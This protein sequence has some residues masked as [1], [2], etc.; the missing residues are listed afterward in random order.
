M[1]WTDGSSDR[2]EMGG[3]WVGGYGVFFL[4]GP[5]CNV[6]VSESQTTGRVELLAV[7]KAL[8]EVTM[9][10]KTCIM[11]DSEYVVNGCNGWAQKWCRND[12]CTAT[13]PVA[14]SD[15]WKRVL[16]LLESYG[17]HVTVYHV[18][19]HAGLPDNAQ[20]D[21]LASQGRLQSPL[22]TANKLLLALLRDGAREEPEQDLHIV[23][24]RESTPLPQPNDFVPWTPESVLSRA[25]SSVVIC[26]PEQTRPSDRM[27]INLD[28]PSPQHSQG[29]I[30][31]EVQ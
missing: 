1:I 31:F 13:G 20:V 15:L 24:V 9:Y 10:R 16:I 14:H 6:P 7:L 25:D 8:Y 21:T 4:D 5:E 17:P 30:D 22:W 11:G 19:S 12:W 23:G 18:P 3:D 2:P 29:F 28:T 26:T 27:F